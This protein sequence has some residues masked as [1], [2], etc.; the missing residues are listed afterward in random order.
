MS[1]FSQR[2][3]KTEL[4]DEPGIPFS[5]WEICLHELNMVNTYLGGHKITVDGVKKILQDQLDKPTLSEKYL[6]ICEIGCGGGDN[7]KAIESHFKKITNEK[8]PLKFIGIDLNKA[9][10]DFASKNCAH[11]N[12]EFICSDYRDVFFSQKPDIIFNSLFCHHFT[13]TQ[14]TEM[15]KWMKQNSV[16]GFFIND[17]QRHPFAYYSIKTLTRLFS[18]SYL[19]KNDGPISVLRGFHKNEWQ[20]LLAASGITRYSIQWRWAFRYLVIVKNE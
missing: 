2:S 5:D 15:L 17:L 16:K 19:V 11:L 4:I 8:I 10:T 18:R 6:T 14:L 9:C 13:N 20:Q 3:L 1:I 12:A 7:L